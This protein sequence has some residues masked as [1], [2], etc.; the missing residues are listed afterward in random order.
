MITTGTPPGT[1]PARRVAGRAESI[2]L[3][4]AVLAAFTDRALERP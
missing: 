4:S 3:D 2:G 1:T